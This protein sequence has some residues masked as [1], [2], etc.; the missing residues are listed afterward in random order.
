MIKYP[1]CNVNIKGKNTSG[2]EIERFNFKIGTN[3]GEELI[4]D[5]DNAHNFIYII[6]PYIHEKYIDKLLEIKKKKKI[7]IVLMFEDNKDFFK[8]TKNIEIFKKLIKLEWI[9]DSAKEETKKKLI[10]KVKRQKNSLIFLFIS[11]ILFF[12]YFSF[13]MLF[14]E[15]YYFITKYLEKFLFLK[16]YLY[17]I[18]FIFGM[19]L[20]ILFLGKIDINKKLQ[21]IS[22][23]STETPLFKTPIRFKCIKNRYLNKTDKPINFSSLH[24]KLY[25]IGL[26]NKKNEDY[27]KIFLGSANLTYAALGDPIER[28]K[29]TKNIE[30]LIKINDKEISPT[31]KKFFFDI[32]N[33]GIP[34]HSTNYIGTVIYKDEINQKL[35]YK[36]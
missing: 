9:K 6:S 18:Y 17:Q 28:W 12:T 3:I 22:K 31:F 16:Q 13:S 1:K 35:T 33:S 29:Q 7:S 2:E 21:F 10:K 27:T 19:Y 32:Y 34:Y 4:E 25:L 26:K 5:F 11:S 20:L 8:E 14:F 30:S 36:F 15:K 23:A 24:V